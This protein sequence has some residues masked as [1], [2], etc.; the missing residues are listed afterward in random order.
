MLLE[1]KQQRIKWNMLTWLKDRIKSAQECDR[2]SEA[3]IDSAVCEIEKHGMQAHLYLAGVKCRHDEKLCHAL[4]TLNAAGFIVTDSSGALV[5][6]VA[7]KNLGSSE[8]AH[9]RRAT[10]RIVE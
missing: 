4:D 9:Q 2:L 5:G 6:G 8:L 1:A 10:F 7:T 3:S